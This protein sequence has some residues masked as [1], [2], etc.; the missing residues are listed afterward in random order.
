MN[1]SS[2]ESEKHPYLKRGF[3]LNPDNQFWRSGNYS[4]SYQNR[5]NYWI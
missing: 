3:Y 1:K 5:M 2:S 4:E